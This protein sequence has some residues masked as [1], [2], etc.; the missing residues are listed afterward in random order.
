MD[1]MHPHVT[2]ALAA[3]K[4]VVARRRHPELATALDHCLRSGELV[5]VLAGVYAAPADAATV[6]IRARAACLADPD[7]VVT[8]PAAALLGGWDH[9]AV[10]GPI[11]VASHS[12][13]R[14]PPGFAFQRRTVPKGLT[15]TADGVRITTFPLTALDLAVERGEAQLDEALRRGVEPAAVKRA[16]DLSRGRRAFWPLRRPVQALRDRP[17]SPL[18]RAAHELL[19]D[20]GVGGWQANRALYDV[21]GETLIGYGDLVF[22]ALG[23]VLELDGAGHHSSGEARVRDANRDLALARAGWE[24]I[25]FGSALVTDAPEQFVAIVKDLVRTRERRARRQPAS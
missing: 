19:R 5:P 15:R 4:G 12:L 25:R 2:A 14:S 20:A 13:R 9:V 23:L 8:G 22:A 11:T 10:T 6:L 21:R 3:G 1:P 17:W 24:V 16:F 7:A 18:E